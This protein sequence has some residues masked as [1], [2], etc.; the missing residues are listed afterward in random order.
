MKLAVPDLISNSYFPAIAAI[1][2]GHFK[3]EGLDVELELLFP[4]NKTYEALR[5]GDIHFVAG[6]SHSALAAFP[7]WKKQKLICAQGQGMYW[8]LMM[9]KSLG[10]KRGDLDIVKGKRI[11]AA[12]WVDMGLKRML[13][14]AGYDLERDRIEIVPVPG[15]AGGEP[16]VNFGLMAAEGLKAG[17]IDGFW[18]N[19]MGAQVAIEAGVGDMVIDVRRGDG[20]SEAFNYTMASIA[21]SDEILTANPG[22]DIATVKAMNKTHSALKADPKLAYDIAKHRFPQE[23]ADLIVPIIKRDLPQYST[24]ISKEFVEGMSVFCQSLGLLKDIKPYETVVSE[25]AIP[26]WT[27]P[28]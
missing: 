12:P 19:G 13:I 15:A 9:D 20:P 18:A 16:S 21:T 8:F 2:L 3:E 14:A 25:A 17:K 23:Q 26:H 5:A 7:D 11:G 10:A 6:S 28:S 4:V 24:G 22:L 1:D 27:W